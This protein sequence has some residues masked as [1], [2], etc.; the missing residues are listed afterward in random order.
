MLC[1][2]DEIEKTIW[3]ASWTT[4]ADLVRLSWTHWEE[5]TRWLR[6]VQW[7]AGRRC[8][9][10]FVLRKWVILKH[11]KQRGHLV[12]QPTW[13]RIRQQNSLFWMWLAPCFFFLDEKRRG[14]VSFAWRR[15]GKYVVN[16][17]IFKKR[18]GRSR[19]DEGCGVG[20]VEGAGL[21]W[22]FE[23]NWTVWSTA[24]ECN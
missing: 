16:C 20:W 1:C 13:Q 6:R 2:W 23:G 4:L 5:R 8:S 10:S 7:M 11:E 22:Q 15:G 18:I 3:I 9:L 19:S 24:G 14:R 12:R 17:V 21:D